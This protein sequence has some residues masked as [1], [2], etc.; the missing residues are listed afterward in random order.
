MNHTGVLTVISGIHTG[1]RHLLQTSDVLVLGKDLDCDIIIQ[2]DGVMDSHCLIFFQTG[3]LI[4]RAL[5]SEVEID[6]KR[7]NKGKETQLRPGDSVQIGAAKIRFSVLGSAKKPE[8]ST[9]YP[10]GIGLERTLKTKGYQLLIAVALLLISTGIVHS[11]LSETNPSPKTTGHLTQPT[12]EVID[13]Q[14]G[15]RMARSVKEILRLSGIEAE[16]RYLGHGEVE[17][18]GIF[19]DVDQLNKTIGSRSITEIA[20]LKRILANNL[21]PKQERAPLPKLDIQTVVTGYDPYIVTTDGSHH[22]IGAEFNNSFVLAQIATD[23]I[24]LKNSVGEEK[25]IQLSSY[26]PQHTTKRE[27]TPVKQPYR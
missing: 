25:I 24:T 17:I 6:G 4:I 5:K 22:Y 19:T 7:L 13:Q 11:G 12:P 10:A 20:G 1:A 2:D 9:R 15:K 14:E 18:T 26:H 27:S 16:S 8:T 21:V 23:E 3:N